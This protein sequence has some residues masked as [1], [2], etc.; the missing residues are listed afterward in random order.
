VGLVQVGMVWLAV[1]H[2]QVW[3]GFLFYTGK[4]GLATRG[5]YGSV[6]SDAHSLGLV[7]LG[8]CRMQ[9]TVDGKYDLK[10]LSNEN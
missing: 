10:V 9:H 8:L 6:V 5:W 3:F 1:I 4:F 2:W 7:W